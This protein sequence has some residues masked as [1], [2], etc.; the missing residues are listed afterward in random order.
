MKKFGPHDAALLQVDFVAAKK[1]HS[2]G[3]WGGGSEYSYLDVSLNNILSVLKARA[4]T[5]MGCRGEDGLGSPGK[6][7]GSSIAVGSPR[8][9]VLTFLGD[10]TSV[11]REGISKIGIPCDNETGFGTALRG[12]G[13]TRH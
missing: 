9:F 3:T 10:A 4:V 1:C 11:G 13:A 2:I 12:T 6:V 7:G 8:R 5:D